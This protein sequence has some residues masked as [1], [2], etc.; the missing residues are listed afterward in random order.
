[1][2]NIPSSY[3][4]RYTLEFWIFTEDI[5]DVTSGVNILWTNH[6]DITV[7]KTPSGTLGAYCFPQAYKIP[8]LLGASG[9]SVLNLF[10]SATNASK[11]DLTIN[12]G[13]WIWVRCAVSTNLSKYYISYMPVA[14]SVNSASNPVLFED[15]APEVL[16]N[17]VSNDYPFKYFFSNAQISSIIVQG[18]SSQTKKIF[19]RNIY[20]FNDYLPH[21]YNF[22]YMYIFFNK[23]T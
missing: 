14:G 15:I 5:S 13:V 10:N 17:N 21:T 12:N 1:M 22:Q 7:M 11:V 9:N 18:I 19:L 6:V 2:S 20:A 16:Y 8:S 4:G 23:G 3:H